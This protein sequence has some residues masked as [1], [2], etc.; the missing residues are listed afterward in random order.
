M[1]DVQCTLPQMLHS[2]KNKEHLTESSSATDPFTC[3]N[4]IHINFQLNYLLNYIYHPFYN[5]TYN[6][7]SSVSS[8]TRVTASNFQSCDMIDVLQSWKN[9]QQTIIQ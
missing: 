2:Y 3:C 7:D 6:C 8:D 5:T 4:L 1:L 9:Q